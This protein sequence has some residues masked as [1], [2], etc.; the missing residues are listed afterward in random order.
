[1]NDTTKKAIELYNKFFTQMKSGTPDKL[2][3]WCA[4]Q[5]INEVISNI[6]ATMIYHPNSKALPVNKQ[7]WLQ[8]KEALMKL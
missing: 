5:V 4:L 6:D 8:V 2:A 3:K 7:Y 1:M